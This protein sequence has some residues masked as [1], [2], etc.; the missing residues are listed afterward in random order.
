MRDHIADARVFKAFC[1]PNRL[2]I[3][4]KLRGG[5]KCACLL[6]EDLGISQ[7]TLSYHMKI[8]CEAGVVQG[9]AEGKWTH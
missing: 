1:D 4:E 3:L 8:L 7:S 6:L 9:R 5:E 2:Q